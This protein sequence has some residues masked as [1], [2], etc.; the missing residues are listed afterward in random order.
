VREEGFS[1]YLDDDDSRLA[2]TSDRASSYA[3]HDA[4]ST[5][6]ELKILGPA[7]YLRLCCY[8]MFLPGLFTDVISTA[9]GISR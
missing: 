5:V 4:G 3:I 2:E 7:M 6:T 1:E 8:F 9:R